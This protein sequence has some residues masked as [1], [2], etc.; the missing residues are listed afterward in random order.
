MLKKGKNDKNDSFDTFFH[1]TGNRY[2]PRAVFVDLE[3]SVIDVIRTGPLKSLC[4]ERRKNDVRRIYFSL[5]RLFVQIIQNNWFPIKK[6]QRTITH[7]VITPLENK[8]SILFSIVFENYR[9]NVTFFSSF[10]LDFLNIFFLL[11]RRWTSRFSHLSFL[12]R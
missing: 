3:E 9:T 10:L 11:L 7:E 1:H 6:T 8:S 5:I 12:R 4:K 2:V